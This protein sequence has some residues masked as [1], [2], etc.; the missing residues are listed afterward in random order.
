M[1]VF[2]AERKGGRGGVMT[3]S[4]FREKKEEERKK[5]ARGVASLHA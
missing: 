4:D 1:R 3:R 2:F 5:R